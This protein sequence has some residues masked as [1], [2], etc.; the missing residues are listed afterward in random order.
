MAPHASLERRDRR[1][2]GLEEV[3]HLVAER[4][5]CRRRGMVRR[6]PPRASPRSRARGAGGRRRRAGTRRAAAS[7]PRPPASTTPASASTGSSSGVRATASCA[8]SAARSS[9]PSS[10]V[11]PSALRRLRRLGGV[12]HDGE[13]RP[14]DRAH[15]RLVRGVGGRGAGR[16]RRRRRPTASSRRERVGEPAQDLREDH[17]RVAP[18]AHERAVRDRL[19]D[20]VHPRRPSPTSAHTDSSVSAMFVPVSPSGTG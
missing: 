5:R 7:K 6:R 8:A 4:R 9:T 15:H 16:R 19:A 2:V 1:V 20:L 18:G 13:D 14:L 3:H 17:A 12:A 10:V 11:A